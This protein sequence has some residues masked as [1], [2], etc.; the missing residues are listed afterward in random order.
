M[1]LWVP[2][3]VFAAFVQNLRFMLQ[4]HLKATQ[5]STGGATFARFVFGAPL[6]VAL[7]L[8]YANWS[9]QSLPAPGL[10]FW[11]FALTG[12]LA[13][14]LATAC[15]VALFALRNF[16]VG[17]TLKNTETIQTALVGFLVLGEGL[18]STAVL[19]VFVGFIGLVFLGDKGGQV[20]SWR[21]RIDGRAL[22]LGLAAGTLFGISAVGYRGASLSLPSGDVLLRASL[23]L[24]LVT[25]SQSA[26]MSLWL[27]AREP[28][29]ML[30]VF[31]AWRVTGLVGLTS[32]LGSLG[33]FTAFTL[34]TA[35]HVRVVGQIELIF[36]YLAS[37][38]FF[39][40][41]PSWRENLGLLLLAAS[42]VLL[43]ISL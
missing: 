8:T 22:L 2:I 29:E 34:T 17:M 13:Q 16:A 35:A 15:V 3:A 12:G 26:V 9:G 20:G 14:I 21:E 6:A 7:A 4:K 25:L 10:E 42:I 18:S 32:M 11:A 5:L 19:A 41:K 38:F 1:A 23:T 30:K 28:G 31:K 27:R 37:I 43:I 36:S 24:A 40:E 39:R 33:W